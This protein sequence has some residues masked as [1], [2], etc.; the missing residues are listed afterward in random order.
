MADW[1]RPSINRLRT[2]K[3]DLGCLLNHAK[4]LRNGEVTTFLAKDETGPSSI[5]HLCVA[6]QGRLSRN[7]Q[8]MPKNDLGC[9]LNLVKRLRNAKDMTL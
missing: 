9:L 1:G 8:R 2:P 7:R 5:G 6:G 4:R 3:N